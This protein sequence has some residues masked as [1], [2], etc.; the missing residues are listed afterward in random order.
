[1]KFV[2][3]RIV[4]VGGLLAEGAEGAQRR[5][6]AHPGIE[7]HQ[8]ERAGVEQ[9]EPSLKAGGL[10]DMHAPPAPEGEQF[11]DDLAID[12]LILDEQN[13]RSG[14]H[15]GRTFPD[16]CGGAAPGAPTG[17]KIAR[18]VPGAHGVMTHLVHESQ[19]Q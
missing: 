11:L 2:C 16:W 1:M 5:D 9:L 8:V 4:G 6:L 18:G 19:K 3:A 13:F 12:L 10:G 14:L 7:Q 17:G 15:G